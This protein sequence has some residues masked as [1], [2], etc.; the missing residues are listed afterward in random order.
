[1]EKTY[2]Q[3]VSPNIWQGRDDSQEDSSAK[4]MFQTINKETFFNPENHSGEIALLG[5]SCDEGVKLNK[6]RTGA[7]D[8]PDNIRKA[9][10]NFASHPPVYPLVDFGNILCEGDNLPHSQRIFS[11]HIK[12]CQQNKMKTLVLGGGHETA[13]AHGLGLYEAHPDSVVGIINFDAHLDIR[14]TKDSSS[15]TPFKQLA[16]YCKTN[17]RPF[18]YLCVGASLAANTQALLTTAKE[19]EVSIIWDTD[20]HLGNLQIITSQIKSF[21]ETTDIIY[22]TIDL[23]VLPAGNMYAVSAPS[24]LGVEP[25]FLLNLLPAII[26]SGKLNAAD[27]VEFNPSLDRDMECARVASRFVWQIF[28]E[29]QKGKAFK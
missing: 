3:P 20:C 26:E 4:R 8:A 27:V 1:M 15:G 11:D 24:A 6:G 23:D 7:K 25:V 9:L 14:T 12:A 5:F 10:A 21:I 13:F 2:W 18:N 28:H 16:D 22:L 29:W 17:N 19:L